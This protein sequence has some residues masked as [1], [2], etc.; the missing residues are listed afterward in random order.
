MLVIR[1]RAMSLF[2][3]PLDRYRVM[4]N[5]TSNQGFSG[6]GEVSDNT[7]PRDRTTK[8]R[9]GVY[10]QEKELCGGFSP[11]SYSPIP[12]PIHKSS[13][14]TLGN[15]HSH[16]VCADPGCR[17]SCLWQPNPPGEYSCGYPPVVPRLHPTTP[18]SSLPSTP[19][20]PGP[21]SGVDRHGGSRS[22][23]RNPD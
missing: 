3:F 21:R 12:V 19:A 16:N 1:R 2:H 14:E 22:G 20:G 7:D 6:L 23:L 17:V 8:V 18:L 11:L 10:W 4:V 15:H 5:A 9:S 13:N